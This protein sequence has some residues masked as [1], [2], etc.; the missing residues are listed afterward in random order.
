[1][2][3]ISWGELLLIGAVALIV[4]GPKE[5]PTVLRTVGQWVT[6]IRRM[7]AEFQGQF[8][9]AMREAELADLKKQVDEVIDPTKGFSAYNPVEVAK[10]EV[11]SA[12]AE[13]DTTT[14]PADAPLSVPPVEP[15]PLPPELTGPVPDAAAAPAPSDALA[16]A[17]AVEAAPPAPAAPAPSEPAAAPAGA[18]PASEGGRA[19]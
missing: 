7:A 2:F 11:E 6:K 5:L 16:A 9:E 13:A 19:A 10:R 1:M 17:S 8:Q 3:D 18:P 12:F 14:A 15:A 4:I